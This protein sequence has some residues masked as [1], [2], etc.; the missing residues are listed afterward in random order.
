ME[1][2]HPISD[3][4]RETKKNLEKGLVN[5]EPDRIQLN[6]L[7]LGALVI[8]AAVV[9]MTNFSFSVGSIANITA[10]TIFLYIIQKKL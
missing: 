2:D 7:M 3:L 9:S 1:S 10:L 5:A 4:R 6:D 8:I